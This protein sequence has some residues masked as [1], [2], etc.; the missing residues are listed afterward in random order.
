MSRRDFTN[1]PPRPENER[2]TPLFDAVAA[3]VSHYPS[4]CQTAPWPQ[5]PAAGHEPRV[6]DL[7][8][9]IAREY[10]AWR[11]TDDGVAVYLHVRKRALELAAG[12]AAVIEVNALW[13]LARRELRVHAN[14]DFRSLCARELR[15]NHQ[16]LRD[17]IRVRKR[18]AKEKDE[19]A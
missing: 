12:G 3:P 19:A 17:A 11:A 1:V 13:A 8:D 9:A 5:A 15:E 7:T 2:G 4:Q 16:I 14:N 10:V 6:A 18:T